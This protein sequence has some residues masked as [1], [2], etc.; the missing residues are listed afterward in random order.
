MKYVNSGR[1]NFPC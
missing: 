1:R